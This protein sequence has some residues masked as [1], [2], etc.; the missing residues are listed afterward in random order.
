MLFSPF[1]P[2]SLYF[3]PT[4]TSDDSSEK[5]TL[6]VF[7]HY[8]FALDNPISFSE[9]IN[10]GMKCT[11]EAISSRKQFYS[12]V[13]CSA[14]RVFLYFIGMIVFCVYGSSRYGFSGVLEFLNILIVTKGGTLLISWSHKHLDWKMDKEFCKSYR[15]PLGVFFP[16]GNLP[17]CMNSPYMSAAKQWSVPL[18]I[19]SYISNCK[20]SSDKCQGILCAQ[21]LIILIE[22]QSNGSKPLV[23]KGMA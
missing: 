17:E 22:D 9:T 23:T 14:T 1:H 12:I 2:F 6:T 3:S 11:K 7:P 10:L 4:E 18:K 13:W 15:I 21:Q 19:A 16:W 8:H 5:P 20:S